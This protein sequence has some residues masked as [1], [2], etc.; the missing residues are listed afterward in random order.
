MS[1]PTCG[2]KAVAGECADG[3][4]PY[5]SGDY[6][7]PFNPDKSAAPRNLRALP[8]LQSHRAAPQAAPQSSDGLE[9]LL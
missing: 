7:C 1:C 9:D 6:P 4:M 2:R 3:F 8:A 5:L